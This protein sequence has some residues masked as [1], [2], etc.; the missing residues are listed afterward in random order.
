MKPLRVALVTMP[1]GVLSASLALA[2]LK[3]AVRLRLGDRVRLEILY[4]V[5]DVARA[6]GKDRYQEIESWPPAPI[7]WLS[8]SA[9][10]PALH[11]NLDDFLS[12]CPEAAQACDRTVLR[13][14]AAAMPSLLEDLV[15]RYALDQRDVLGFTFFEKQHMAS[16]ALAGIVKR[17]NP[18]LITLFGGPSCS[19]PMGE[20]LVRNVPAIDFVFSGPAMVTLPVLLEHLLEGHHDQCHDI[21][22]VFSRPKLLRLGVRTNPESG[23]DV[24]INADLPLDY[25]DYFE[26]FHRHFPRDTMTWPLLFETSRGCWWGE[27]CQCAFCAYCYENTTFQPMRPDRALKEFTRVRAYWPRASR[28]GMVDAAVPPHYTRTVFP[29][30]TMPEGSSIFY[31]VRPTLTAD[32]LQTMFRAGVREIKVGIESLA[33]RSL[34]LMRKGTTAFQNIQFL[35]NCRYTRLRVG[36]NL[37][38]GAPGEPDSVYEKYLLD[39]PRCLHLPP[40]TAPFIIALLRYSPYFREAEKYGIRPVP[41][42]YYEK[43]YPFDAPDIADFAFRFEDGNQSTLRRE[44]LNSWLQRLK[45]LIAEWRGRWFRSPDRIPELRLRYEDGVWLVF[46]SRGAND[47]YLPIS[48]VSLQLLRLLE[49]PQ[50]LVGLPSKLDGVHSD[51]VGAELARLRSEGLLFEEGNLGMSLVVLPPSLRSP[52][53]GRM[54]KENNERVVTA[55]SQADYGL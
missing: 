47:R 25:E 30:V 48:E 18:G 9:A 7:D 54:P 52:D 8:R 33:T 42:P 36:W 35:K 41:A 27:R 50:S 17:R 34:K 12:A 43:L 16:L 5:H 11:D 29:H 31:E 44:Q 40:P 13:T 10:F 19:S 45:K 6:L 24:D 55:G 15:S 37:L 26:S 38:I 14:V 28:F 23:A 46:D 39:I 22:G 49:V 4:L 32:E 21:P 20:V 51:I 53:A 2:K 1:F 3:A